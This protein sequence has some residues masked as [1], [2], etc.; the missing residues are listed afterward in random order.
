MFLVWISKINYSTTPRAGDHGVLF[1]L[2]HWHLAY[3]FTGN[4]KKCLSS[5]S[6]PVLNWSHCAFRFIRYLELSFL[7]RNC[8]QNMSHWMLVHSAHHQTASSY[9]LKIQCTSICLY[10]YIPKRICFYEINSRIH[11]GRKLKCQKSL[12]YLCHLYL[13]V[14]HTHHQFLRQKKPAHFYSRKIL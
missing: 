1:F 11:A 5:K 2:S 3:L 8:K 4:T 7:K 10:E 9:L 14:H 6:Q 13:W 12:V